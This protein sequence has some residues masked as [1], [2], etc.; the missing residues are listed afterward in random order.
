MTTANERRGLVALGVIMAIVVLSLLFTTRCG[1][2]SKPATYDA[3]NAADSSA[4]TRVDLRDS[5]RVVEIEGDYKPRRRKPGL[6][7]APKQ[8]PERD[9]LSPE[10]HVSN[11]GCGHE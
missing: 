10:E 3:A 1:G 8:Y 2:D 4:V 9:P 11:S 7:R 5:L 6:V